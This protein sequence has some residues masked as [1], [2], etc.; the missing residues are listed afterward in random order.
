MAYSE[1]IQTNV[2]IDHLGNKNV[3]TVTVTYKD[4]V[5]VG[6]TNHRHVIMAEDDVPDDIAAFIEAKKVAQPTKAE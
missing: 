4:G 1:E 3:R 6:S 5:E 2:T